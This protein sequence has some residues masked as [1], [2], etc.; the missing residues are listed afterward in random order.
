MSGSIKIAMPCV[1]VLAL[2]SAELRSVSFATRCQTTLNTLTTQ[3]AP[4]S[5][6]SAYAQVP[7]AFAINRGQSAPD[8]R[9]ESRGPGY[10]LAL[11][12]TD[13][14]I[15]LSRPAAAVRMAF[16][17]ANATP[18]VSGIDELAGKANYLVGRDPTAWRTNVPTYAKVASRDLY[19]GIDVVYYGQQRQLEYDLIVAPGRDPRRIAIRF[20]GVDPLALT[21]DGDLLLR[22]AAGDIRQQKPVMYQQVG[23]SRRIVTG[24][25]R[26]TGPYEVGF[27]VDAYDR[28]RPLVIDPV[29]A[30]ATYLDTANAVAVDAAGQAYVIGSTAASDAP[31]AG[32]RFGTLLQSNAVV[33]RLTADGSALDYV[34]LLGGSRF[35]FGFDI[36]VDAAGHAFLT[37]TTN[38]LDFPLQNPFQSQIAF[39]GIPDAFLAELTPA[40]NALV[41]STYFGGIGEETDLHLALDRSGNI[42]LGLGAIRNPH[43]PLVNAYQTFFA[44]DQDDAY[45]VKFSPGAASIIYAT[46]LGGGQPI[47]R[48][49]EIPRTL[50]VDN[51]GNAYFLGA[52]S[53][54]D[55]PVLNAI[56]PT[57]RGIGDS[58]LAKFDPNGNA[59][60]VTY[61]GDSGPTSPVTGVAVDAAGQAILVGVSSTEF[62]AG[63]AA[64]GGF[65]LT[66][67][68]DGQQFV[69]SMSLPGATPATV[70]L[71]AAGNILLSGRAG[72]GLPLVNPIQN[73]L[74]GSSDAF[75]T[76]IAGDLSHVIY[77][78]YL[79]GTDTDQGDEIAVDPAGSAYI[80]GETA[81]T[82]FP[83]VHPLQAS[84]S[85]G[86]RFLAKI[87]NF[88]VCLQ[89][90]RSD[91]TLRVNFS[92][93]GY[94]FGGCRGAARNARRLGMGS[95]SRTGDLAILMDQ[96]LF[97]VYH[98]RLH[99]AFGTVTVGGRVFTINDTNTTDNTCACR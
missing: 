72:A 24:R 99:F 14:S 94:E 19:P 57:M 47:G 31:T 61:L 80:L 76:A 45:L 66:L 96:G 90:D 64:S 21:D 15:T 35:D 5:R 74:K 29:I 85:A 40:G 49:S 75:V 53:S 42:F 3:T 16:V 56:Q 27:V 54:T 98:T 32:G 65:V 22:T 9:F 92:D 78:T 86:G 48:G 18:T 12:A 38:S 60:Y 55:F 88:E 39:L 8:V 13:A 6:A 26:L 87:S 20:D 4:A 67:S 33:M 97:I 2:G 10:S 82:D 28:S 52:T 70:A 25:Y 1:L 23:E 30:Y 95:V 44:G 62:P 7:L 84:L 73:T 37:G 59:I 83:V 68:A 77:S 43:L 36:A 41:F 71:D 79:G 91:N 69:R 34:T 11:R 51:A 63:G 17:G 81:S 89:D 46:Y 93:G 50:A 58:F